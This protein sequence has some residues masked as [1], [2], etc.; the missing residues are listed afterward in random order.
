MTGEDEVVWWVWPVTMV[1]AVDEE[2]V[3]N[4]W[5]NRAEEVEGK[6]YDHEW[7]EEEEEEYV[8]CVC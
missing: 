8:S 1:V 2:S 6:S 4:V 5:E 3:G 7:E